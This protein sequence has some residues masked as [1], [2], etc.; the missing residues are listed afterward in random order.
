MDTVDLFLHPVR[1]RIVHAMYDG[2]ARTTSELCALLSDVSQATVYR[3]VGHLV[4]G[5]VL[6]V[7]SEERVRGAIERRYVL[8]RGKTVIDADTAASMSAE[9]YRR[10][11]AVAAA[12]LQAEFNAYLDREGADPI[13]DLVGFRQHAL[14]LS[15][16]ELAGMIEDLRAVIMARAGNEPSPERVRHMFSLTLFPGEALPSQAPDA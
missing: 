2:R 8:C 6:A 15:R 1:M 13:H 3:H 14:W 7:E 9:D 4:G 12:T 5:E 16:D 10:T 11:F